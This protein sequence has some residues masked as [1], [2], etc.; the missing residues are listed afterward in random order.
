MTEAEYEA[1]VTAVVAD[2]YEAMDMVQALTYATPEQVKAMQ[3]LLRAI[4]REMAAL[5][6]PAY[7]N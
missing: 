3:A 1:E 4:A 7:V 2:A 6:E 5:L